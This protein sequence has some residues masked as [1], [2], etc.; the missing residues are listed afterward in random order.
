MTVTIT[1]PTTSPR[2]MVL[3][4]GDDIHHDLLSAAPY[5]TRL[6]ADAGFVARAAIGM[7][8]FLDPH[9]LT[10]AQDVFCVYKAGGEFSAAQQAALADRVR[11]GAGLV[12][13]HSS[14]VLGTTADGGLDE[15]FRPFFDLLGNRYLSHGPGHHEGHQKVAVVT[16]H[17]ITDGVSDF[18]LFDEFYEFEFS[19]DDHEVLAERTRDDGVVIPVL[20]A[21]HYGA[22]RVVYLASGHDLRAWGEPPFIRLVQQSLQWAAGLR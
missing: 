19:D 21:R 18:E 12:A 9:P 7:Q 20:Y 10:A 22:G 11:S 15:S 14:N 6:A 13:I 2:A 1:S 8:R 16:R 17:P 3:V 5:L 4:S